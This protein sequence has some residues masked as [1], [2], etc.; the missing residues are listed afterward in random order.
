MNCPSLEASGKNR[1]FRLIKWRNN[2]LNLD[3]DDQVRCYTAFSEVHIKEKTADGLT[4]ICSVAH[5]CHHGKTKLS[6]GKAK[7][8]YSRIKLI[9]GNALKA[10]QGKRAG[11]RCSVVVIPIWNGNS[12][13]QFFEEQPF[14][15]QSSHGVLQQLWISSWS[16][17]QFLYRLR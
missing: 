5:N 2:Y 11:P 14:P 1:G 17:W 10:K 13:I 8:T 9:H 15:G 12:C 16:K 4:L 7:L 6:D 3:H